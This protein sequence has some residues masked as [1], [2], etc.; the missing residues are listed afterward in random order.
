MPGL[1]Y[2][3]RDEFRYFPGK[4]AGSEQAFEMVENAPTTA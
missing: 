1:R 3:L 4:T 2:I